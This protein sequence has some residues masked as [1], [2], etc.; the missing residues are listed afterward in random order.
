[1]ISWVKECIFTHSIALAAD[2]DVI[3]IVAGNCFWV[4]AAPP[5][6]HIAGDYEKKCEQ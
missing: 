1:V 4:E 6:Q 3:H 5:C 2:V